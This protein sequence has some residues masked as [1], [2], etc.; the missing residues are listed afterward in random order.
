LGYSG[1]IKDGSEVLLTSSNESSTVSVLQWKFSVP[2]FGKKTVSSVSKNA[3]FTEAIESG[4]VIESAEE[5]STDDKSSSVVARRTSKSYSVIIREYRLIVSWW[6]IVFLRRLSTCKTA[7]EYIEVVNEYHHLLNQRLDQHVALYNGS[8]NRDEFKKLQVIADESKA[9]IETDLVQKSLTYY[10]SV[11]EK[12]NVSVTE[13]DITK[14]VS[15]C[16]SEIEK[17]LDI[18]APQEKKHEVEQSAS[19]VTIAKSESEVIQ[20]GYVVVE[21]IR[22]TIRYWYRTLFRQI[23]E[24]SNN[25]ASKSEIDALVKKSHSELNGK[26]AQI[27]S[28]CQSS[29]SGVTINDNVKGAFEGSI[30]TAIEKSN[31]GVAEFVEDVSSGKINYNSEA[32]WNKATDSVTK[33]LAIEYNVCQDK[34]QA[35]EKTSHVTNVEVDEESAKSSSLDLVVA[36]EE[37]KAYISS[38]FTGSLHDITWSVKNNSSTN[39]LATIVDA[40]EIDLIS[41]I[42]ET[43]SMIAIL[44]GQLT[45]LSLSERRRITS[46]LIT[47]RYTLLN[48]LKGL[49]YA[50]ETGDKDSILRISESTFS[51]TESTNTL[52]EVDSA[53]ETIQVKITY[54]TDVGSSSEQDIIIGDATQDI[55]SV[56]KTE[57]IQGEGAEQ[58]QEETTATKTN[59][60]IDTSKSDN[61]T[62]GVIGSDSKIKDQVEI[63]TEGDKNVEIAIV[64]GTTTSESANKLTKAELD[65]DAKKDDKITVAI[66]S[67]DLKEIQEVEVDTTKADNL[68]IQVEGK[69][70][71]SKVQITEDVLDKQSEDVTT[72]GDCENK[73]CVSTAIIS[74]EGEVVAKDEVDSKH[75]EKVK[76]GVAVGVAGAA[77]GSGLAA[78]IADS[79]KKKHNEATTVADVKKT[80]SIAAVIETEQSEI[81]AEGDFDTNESEKVA[82]GVV[83]GDIKETTSASVVEVD[84]KPVVAVCPTKSE[85]IDDAVV[86]KSLA[87]ILSRVFTNIIFL[88]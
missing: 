15:T 16:T 55:Q 41:K 69:K 63:E 46:F 85:K 47:I 19:V 25:G 51:Q 87:I 42:D 75:S 36:V 8:L 50:I 81:I 6:R 53:L 14:A 24:A 68:K 40:A 54:K 21:T 32:D 22:V 35:V 45:Y 3:G 30:T 52:C 31:E 82:V 49:R 2:I 10:Q 73:E 78:V 59:V 80:D 26:L 33:K 39:D 4:A 11:D 70:T 9:S 67:E 86:G 72:T 1:Q 38:W 62:I 84:V 48:K 64:E 79:H 12:K 13:Y 17:K 71:T 34:I 66:V 77:I 5:V 58:T 28:S 44:S 65:V 60:I 23:S 88:M 83:T 57:I 29:V 61:V 37:F 7:K 76:V 20:N 18:I 74:Q 27:K 56:V 43:S